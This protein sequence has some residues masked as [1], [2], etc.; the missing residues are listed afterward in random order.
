MLP[1]EN[2]VDDLEAKLNELLKQYDTQT[3]EINGR[4]EIA[5][6]TIAAIGD[7]LKNAA[8]ANVESM[9]AS[10]A[11]IRSR[12]NAFYVGVYGPADPNVPFPSDTEPA[13]A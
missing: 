6:R 4:L 13:A 3:D 9:S 7:T 2:R 5:E 8:P 1:L 10:L 12:V 11:E